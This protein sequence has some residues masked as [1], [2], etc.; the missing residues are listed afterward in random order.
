MAALRVGA[1]DGEAMLEQ[2]RYVHNVIVPPAAVSL[3]EVR[4]RGERYRLE[5]AYLGGEIVGCSTVR[6][7]EGEE[8]VATVIARVL[9]AFRGRGIG[10]AL[11]GRGLAHARGLGAGAVGTV[12][13]AANAEGLRFARARGFAEWERYVLDGG[14]D[15]WVDLRLASFPG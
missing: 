10:T 14:S 12:V 8:R 3:D 5:N 7:P 4:E 13:L 6:P 11:Y 15:E 9:P 1:V 2:W